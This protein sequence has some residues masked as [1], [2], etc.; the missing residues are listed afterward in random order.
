MPIGLLGTV[1]GFRDLDGYRRATTR[2]RQLGCEGSVCIHPDQVEIANQ[3]FS[4]PPEKV[5]HARRVVEAFEGGGK[6]VVSLDGKMVDIPVANRAR[7]ILERAEAIAEL[8]ERKAGA[9]ARLK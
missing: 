7:L 4:P 6:G 1:G 2:A 8:E 9:L 3:V 5:E